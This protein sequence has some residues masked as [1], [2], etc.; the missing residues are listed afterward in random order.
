MTRIEIP[1]EDA[2]PGDIAV[3]WE[4]WWPREI[5]D[6]VFSLGESLFAAGYLV[7]HFSG[8]D[9]GSRVQRIYREV[10]DLPTEPGSVIRAT[11]RGVPDS[12]VFQ[13][14]GIWFSPEPIAGN[15]WHRPEVIDLSTVRVGR[16]VFEEDASVTDEQVEA[17]KSEWHRADSEGD[18]GNRVRR[19]LQAALLLHQ[20]KEDAS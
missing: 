2:R 12:E 7:R 14:L 17:F 19:A 9:P 8:G 3:L 11:V 15:Y 18:S 16:I 13:R 5:E 4:D 1:V 20:S 10:P 6:E